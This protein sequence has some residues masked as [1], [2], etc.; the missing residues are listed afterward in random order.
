MVHAQSPN[1]QFQ[2]IIIENPVDGTLLVQIPAGPFLAGEREPFKVTLPSDYLAL[3]PVTNAQYA[4]FAKKTVRSDT[5]DHPVVD[6]SW[7]DAQAYCKWAG[8]RLPSELEWEK[9]ARG[10]DGREYP[11]RAGRQYVKDFVFC[12]GTCDLS[13]SSNGDF[14]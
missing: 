9:G 7:N 5:A 12:G 13:L 14:S 3:H 10:D 2:P 1:S 8:L 4:R 6:V 11:W